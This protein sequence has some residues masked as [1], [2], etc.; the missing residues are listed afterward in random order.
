[1]L[2]KGEWVWVDSKIGVP[3]GARVKKA[4]TN[5][6]LLVDD[7]GKER[8]LKADQQA[9]A[10]PMHATSVEGVDDM[11]QLGDLSEAGLLRNLLVRHRKGLI[12]TYTGSVLVAVNPY[13]DLP[14]YTQEQVKLYHGQKL[15]ELPPHVFAIADTC[16]YNLKRYDTDQCCIISGES[17]AGKTESSKLILQYL[18]AISG[19]RSNLEQQILESNPILEAFGNAKT[20]RNDNSSRFGKYLE[21]SF[22]QD[23]AIEGA[24]V[25]QYLLEKCR[26]CH[27]AEAERNFHIF[28]CMLAGLTAEQKDKLSLKDAKAYKFLTRGGSIVCNGRDDA[29]DFGRIGGALKVLTFRESQSWEIYKLLAAILHLGN[30]SF[31][32]TSQNNMDSSNVCSSEHF[33]LASSMLEVPADVLERSMTQRSFLTN[34]ETVTKPLNKEQ[35]ADCRDALVKAVYNKMFLWI[36]GKINGIIGKAVK[37]DSGSSHRSIGLLDIFGFENFLINS[38]EQLCI[39]LANEKLQQFFVVNIFELEQKEYFRQG[40]V[41]DNITFSD[42]KPT[43]ELLVSKPCNLL[44]MID[45]ESQFPKGT[46]S[47]MLYKMNQQHKENKGYVSSKNEHDSQFGIKHFAGQVFYDSNGFLEKNR[48][49]ISSNIIMMISI[50]KNKLLHDI[51]KSE[52]S[53]KGVKKSANNKVTIITPTHSLRAMGDK[54]QMPTLSGQFRRSL[55]SL[56]K[57]LDACQPFF[58]R[59][60]KPNKDKN[61]E[62]FD[63]ELCMVQLR[64]SGM[65]DTVRIRKLGFPIRHTFKDFMFRYRVLLNTAV[66]DPKKESDGA[67]CQA[68][69]TALI[70][71]KDQWKVG[72]SKIFLKD[73]HDSILEQAR[74]LALAKVVLII[75]RV[76]F[77]LHDRRSYLKKKAAVRVLQTNWRA[78]KKRERGRK[79]RLGYARLSARVRGRRLQQLY[80]RQRSAAVVLQTQVRGYLARKSWKQQ[81]EDAFNAAREQELL[82]RAREEQTLALAAIELQKLADA[83]AESQRASQEPEPI[84]DDEDSDVGGDNKPAPQLVSVAERAAPKNV[85]NYPVVEIGHKALKN[86]VE[87]TSSSSSSDTEEDL[88][89]TTKTPPSAGPAPP[90]PGKTEEEE[91]KEKKK[92]EEE[93][94]EEEPFKEDKEF[95]FQKFCS[96]H[97]QGDASHTHISQRLRQPLLAHQDER[98]SLA[99]LTVWWIILRFMGDM[100]EPRAPDPSNPQ[101]RRTSS[102]YHPSMVQRQGRRLS[103][104]VGLDQ[105]ILRKNKKKYGGGNRRAS[106][107]PEEPEDAREEDVL[108]GEG[109]T[110]DRPLTPLE[111]LHIIV[112]YGLSRPGIRDEIFCQILKQLMGNGDKEECLRGWTLLSMCLSSFPPS[113]MLIKYLENFLRRGPKGYAAYCAE[114]LRRT[115]ANGER[116]EVPCEMELQATE[117]KKPMDVTVSLMDGRKFTLQV[118]AACTSGEVLGE[119]AQKINLSDTYGFSLYISIMEKRWSL[120]SSGKHVMDSVSQCE[121]AVRQQ[122]SEESRAPWQLW[123]R[124]EMFTPWHDCAVD[125]V[126]TELIYRQVLL[127]LKAEEYVCDK[128]DEY[129]QLAAK[130]YF[131]QFGAEN[132][133]QNTRRAVE[134]CITS[135]LIDAKSRA[136]W[137]QLVGSIHAQG[138]YRSKDV[139]KADLVDY[140]R[141]KWSLFFSKFY[142][143]TMQSGPPLPLSRFALAINSTGV[144]FMDGKDTKLLEIPNV[145]LTGATVTRDSRPVGGCLRLSTFQ[146]EFVLRCAEAA[147]A[148]KMIQTNLEGLRQRSPYAVAMQELGQPDDPSVLVCKRGELLVVGREGDFSAARRWNTATNSNSGLSG[149]VQMNTIQFLSTLDMPSEATLN[150]LN[151]G[152]NQPRALAGQ[153]PTQ[154]EEAVAPVSIKEFALENFGTR[155][156]GKDLNRVGATQLAFRERLWVTSKE[157]LKQ[158][159]LRTLTNNSELSTIA[160]NAFVAI[161]K[162]MGD[163]PIKHARS[164]MELTDQ[165]FGPATQHPALQDEIYCQIMKQMT[166]NRNRVSMELGWQLL[167]LC[168][169]LFP[170]SNSLAKHAHRFLKSRPRDPLASDCLK[171]LQNI[172]S[173]EPRQHPPHYAEVDAIHRNS[174]Q[175]YHKV[176]FPNEADELFEVTSTTTIRDLCSTIATQLNLS[177]PDG[178]GLFM[179]TAVKVSNLDDEMYFFDSLRQNAE[180]PKKIKKAKEATPSAF[181]VFFMRKLW[182][183]VIPGRDLMADLTFHYPQE[184]PRYLRGYHNCS[185]EDMI[186]LAALLFRIQTDSDRSQFVMIPRML[187]ELVPD[188]QI[189]LMSSDEWKKNIISSYNQQMGITADEARVNFLKVISSWPTFGCTFFEVKQTCESSYPTNMRIAISK[190][191][192]SFIDPKTKE[193]L[194]MHPFGKIT[195]WQTDNH[196]FHMSIGGLVQGTFSCETPLGYK[197]EDL[198]LSY[199]SMYE[200]ERLSVLPRSQ[201]FS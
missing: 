190:V 58:I 22:N 10:R 173:L 32:E 52:L 134:D 188:D 69:C 77:G 144:S 45:E 161:L 71:G 201:M 177:S 84:S 17:G 155:T 111:K 126:S 63:R 53:N 4:D 172:L 135:S 101:T 40:V 157:P 88:P 121:H 167:W 147:E 62:G 184:M 26:V 23:G 3:I 110:L 76:M 193:L 74:E 75:Q 118:D 139:A 100:A 61:S 137:N 73:A 182:F 162:Y 81:K 117:S 44:A 19:R 115:V 102:A 24:R 168:T 120:G 145:E 179:K 186:E 28:Y 48:D 91:E 39:N 68:I 146:D 60:F 171:R 59:C 116:E 56:M 93:E 97:F 156:A 198:L 148:A 90:P 174:T 82:A 78:Y 178:Y 20:I 125:P 153:G 141:Q 124:K 55:E 80:E 14:L 105:K 89:K 180:P 70:R 21:I 192:V 6:C 30:I 112:G 113:Q 25:E 159:L 151:P 64:Y 131:V 194:V 154:R 66:C 133:P 196:H 34:R 140:A 166:N 114:R 11:I 175:I 187:K 43:L 94:E 51:F 12:Y 183:N 127:G 96:L 104:M 36:V 15:G 197:M 176:T 119:V 181:L 83:A 195:D 130:H 189:D 191:G 122:G 1:M 95:S 27:Q 152:Y 199:I 13:K 107:I 8:V 5:Q 149:T 98:D 138:R 50:S 169:G 2:R 170:P 65:M 92:K 37:E 185:R 9:S 46:D 165:I 86:I 164:P 47:T 136:K 72:K 31:E 106:T 87:E 7:E 163:Y 129:A 103:S 109:P 33:T 42:N 143:V 67:C 54:K 123:V 158:P 79:L 18:A 200:K 49:A 108:I 38:F 150:L 29:K 142:A 85:N 132:T 57:A 160:C 16:Y 35:A 99:C 41:W 128:E